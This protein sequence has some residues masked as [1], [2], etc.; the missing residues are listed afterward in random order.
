MT[1]LYA[2]TAP[3]QQPAW[4][5]LTRLAAE[6][7]SRSIARLLD[8]DARN[9]RLW[10]PAPGITLD[11]SRQR[12]DAAVLDALLALAAQQNLQAA[13]QAL[14]AGAEVNGTERRPAL[15]MA[16]RGQPGDFAGIVDA[17]GQAIEPAVL[18]TRRRVLDLARSVRDGSL[19]GH[20]GKAI[21]DLVHIGIG[22]SHL[23]PEL[24]SEAIGP[25]PG[26]PR[27]HFVAN[28]DGDALA[29]VL[30]QV[31]PETT[32]FLVVSKSFSTLETQVN[33]RSSRS[34]FL[35][36]TGSAGAVE[37]HFM[38][39]TANVGAA[40][41]FGISPT[42][43]FPMWDWVGGRYSLWS[44]VGL[45]VAVG[46][47]PEAFSRLLDGARAMDRHF[48]ESPLADNAPA[49][50][51]LLDI[52]NSN[53]LGAGC[54]AV[55]PYA[56]RLRRLPD[57]LQQLE[58]ESN[59]KSVQRDGRP[60]GVHTMPVVW[61]GEGT[62]GQHAFHQLLHQGTRAVSADFVLV[63]DADHELPDHHR[64]LLA[65]GIAQSQALMA[66]QANDDP[67][68]AVAGEHGSNTL[69]L[70]RLDP[71][72]LGA[73]LALHEHRVFCQ[74]VIWNINSFDQWGVEL[75]KRLALPI[76]D[77]LGGAPAA[78]QDAATR[79][80]VGRLRRPPH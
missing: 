45:P 25:T 61:G 20:S 66:G 22:G 55:L 30:A 59:G 41:E 34:W 37:H 48:L 80:L 9:R 56:H 38:A 31:D 3:E 11:G 50:C 64:W 47:G 72:S 28:V 51:A 19:R 26:A 43:V 76:F 36:R 63:A 35:E 42:R 57:Y 18:E 78:T 16:L 32:L 49:L 60:V 15:H 71:H 69:L 53:F 44:A 54:H 24:V 10:V 21:R 65:N 4:Q 27:C 23:G 1:D 75:G 5:T 6:A 14:F 13:I 73:L 79:R 29:S 52:W 46:C 58:M 62:N 67:H 2:A 74:G 17:G 12:L 33:A 8:D 70:D 7:G 40:A 68:R 77:Q 39:V